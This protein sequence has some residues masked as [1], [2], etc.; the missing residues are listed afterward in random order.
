MNGKIIK[1]LPGSPTHIHR[2]ELVLSGERRVVEFFVKAPQRVEWL[3]V[4]IGVKVERAERD[5]SLV[6]VEHRLD[7]CTG[8]LV[9]TAL[10]STRWLVECNQ[11]PALCQ[12]GEVLRFWI[13]NDTTQ[14]ADVY[15]TAL[16]AVAAEG[17]TA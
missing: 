17:P 5:Q 6:P 10:D 15:L 1:L 9:V 2:D 7:E 3:N 8:P 11:R 4:N 12:V 16:V 13:T 14:P